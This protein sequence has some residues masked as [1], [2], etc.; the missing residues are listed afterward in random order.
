M[1]SISFC[2]SLVN[3]PGGEDEDLFDGERDGAASTVEC[4]IAVPADMNEG[5]FNELRIRKRTNVFSTVFQFG[6]IKADSHSRR[7]ES[8]IL[9]VRAQ[10]GRTVCFATE[11]RCAG[12]RAAY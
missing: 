9:T 12:S 6:V 10:E 2:C 5:K 3:F 11:M 8:A 1:P 4:S 7:L